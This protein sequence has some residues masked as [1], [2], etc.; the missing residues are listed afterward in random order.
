MTS[1][2]PRF[3]LFQLLEV[4]TVIA[5]TIA[6]DRVIMG[7]VGPAVVL[8]GGVT[9]AYLAFRWTSHRPSRWNDIWWAIGSSAAATFLNA[10]AVGIVIAEE[11]RRTTN[12]EYF[13]WAR[14]GASFGTAIALVTFGGTVVGTLVFAVAKLIVA[15]HNTKPG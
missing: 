10:S 1:V 3:S 4:V 9:G 13:D 5:I 6:V 15:L 11:L 12:G 14:D 7:L 8:M 2:R